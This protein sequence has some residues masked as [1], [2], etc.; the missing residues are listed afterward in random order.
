M[1][2]LITQGMT[3]NYARKTFNPRDKEIYG[4]RVPRVPDFV[5][6]QTLFNYLLAKGYIEP[7]EHFK[8]GWHRTTIKGQAL[9]MAKLVPRVDSTRPKR[10][11]RACWSVAAI[12]ADPDMM[13]WVTE[14]AV[15][16]LCALTPTTLVISTCV[17]QGV[18]RSRLY[19][20]HRSVR[21]TR[22]GVGR[23]KRSA[24]SEWSSNASK[25]DHLIIS[26]HDISE[27]VKGGFDSRT[28]YAFTPPRASSGDGK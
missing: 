18:N 17:R 28:V 20:C 3:R 27:V 13:R 12:D 15:G 2:G 9:K 8:A 1:R 11:L 7:D 24:P 16:L 23:T 4:V 21:E 22:Q 5:P 19:R 14:V 10:C 6:A 26:M 25:G